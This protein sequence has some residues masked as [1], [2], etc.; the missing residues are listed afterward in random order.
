LKVSGAKPQRKERKLPPHVQERK[1]GEHAFLSPPS[2]EDKGLEAKQHE[3][4][5]KMQVRE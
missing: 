2:N 5:R 4:H 1:E 3:E